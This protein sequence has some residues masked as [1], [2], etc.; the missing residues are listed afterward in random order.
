M[1]PALQLMA[2][3]LAKLDAKA[4]DRRSML[5]GHHSDICAKDAPLELSPY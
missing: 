1:T 3:F 5:A 4:P 2:D